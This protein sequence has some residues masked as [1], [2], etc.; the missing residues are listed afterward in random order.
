M[1][2]IDFLIIGSG[3]YGATMARIL[4]DAG[5]TCLILEKRNHIAGNIY[6]E[7]T[8]DGYD[9]HVYGPHIF[10]TDK[11][12]VEEFVKKYATWETFKLNILANNNGNIYHLPFFYK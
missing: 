5:Y 2:N 9:K 6:S 4:T 3:L 11:P 10:H 7:R 1:S 8:N 12:D